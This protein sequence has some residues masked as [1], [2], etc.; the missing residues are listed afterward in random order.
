MQE[1]LYDF[2]ETV[3]IIA[4]KI[5]RFFVLSCATT[6]LILGIAYVIFVCFGIGYFIWKFLVITGVM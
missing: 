6:V 2:L 4:D 3:L 1:R 5:R